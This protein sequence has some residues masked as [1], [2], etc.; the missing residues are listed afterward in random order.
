MPNVRRPKLRRLRP[1]QPRGPAPS[2]SGAHVPERGPRRGSP[3]V[4]SRV[5]CPGTNAVCCCPRWRWACSLHRCEAA[6][7]A[8]GD[9]GPS[10]GRGFPKERGE[11]CRV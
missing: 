10:A 5:S 4:L 3:G 8:E 1:R 11:P 7:Q 6:R 9:F 2:L